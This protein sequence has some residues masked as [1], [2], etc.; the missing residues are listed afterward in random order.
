M[1]DKKTT[2]YPLKSNF[3]FAIIAILS[4]GLLLYTTIEVYNCKQDINQINNEIQKLSIVE[5]V[6]SDNELESK[7]ELNEL[8]DKKEQKNKIGIDDSE[9]KFNSDGSIDDSNWINDDTRIKFKYPDTWFRLERNISNMHTKDNKMHSEQIVITGSGMPLDLGPFYKKNERKKEYGNAVKRYIDR[10]IEYAKKYKGTCIE[11]KSDVFNV[12]L[13]CEYKKNGYKNLSYSR[14][15]SYNSSEKK[16]INLAIVDLNIEF[17][18]KEALKDNKK[19]LNQ[20]LN[21]AHIE[22]ML[23]FN[24]L[25]L[26]DRKY[27]K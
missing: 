8:G 17:G 11:T 26:K 10:S 22:N 5:K 16:E 18:S 4:V 23:G 1:S 3:A 14:T 12:Y 15:F 9:L 21:D 27:L 13:E 25:I 6:K 2:T 7:K 19:I 24:K 20:I